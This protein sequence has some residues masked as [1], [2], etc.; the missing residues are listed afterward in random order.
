MALSQSPELLVNG[1]LE[2][3]PLAQLLVRAL[4]QRLEGT[5]VLQTP[6]GVK[7][8][9]L[10]LRGAPA[11]A[12]LATNLVRLAEVVVDLEL[13]PRS[14]A[15]STQ[16]R[17]VSAGQSHEDVLIAEGHL[18]EAG[19]YLALREL[20]SRQVLKLCDLPGETMFGVYRA[21]YLANEGPLTEWRVKPLPLVWRALVDHFPTDWRVQALGRLGEHV[22]KMR[23]EAPVSRYHLEKDE[24]AVIDMLKARPQSL[25]KLE[26]SGVAS[27][28]KVR[29]IAAALLLTRQLEGSAAHGAPVGTNEPPET[30]HSQPPPSK[31]AT[32][33]ATAARRPQVFSGPPAS[34]RQSLPS[35]TPGRQSPSPT[36]SSGGDVEVA[37]LR[38][39]IRDWEAHPRATFYEVLG[40][41]RDTDNAGI[42][43]AFF[44]L[45][46]TWHPDRLPKELHEQRA[47]VTKAFA[48]M[49]EAHQ[50]LSDKVRR[51]EYDEKIDGISPEEQEKVAEILGASSAF[52]R[53]EV[54]VKKKDYAAALIEAK[55]AFEGD[56]SQ[57]D[58]AGLFAWL[59]MREGGE[60]ERALSIISNALRR[61]PNNV[62]VLFFRAQILRK[63][64]KEAEAIRDFKKIIAI[65]PQH[66]EA[67][68]ELRVHEMRRR[69]APREEHS[70][71]LGRFRRKS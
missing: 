51:A 4:D 32:D 49:G 2:Q 63:A 12:K 42:R 62:R 30:P 1:R 15:V 35:A 18:D 39:L 57:A 43:A 29:K 37:A 8:A 54:L 27:A 22:L 53:A 61:E 52:Q 6:E 23:F 64:G 50:V 71:L 45:A 10:L 7:H 33:R 44:Q 16:K 69:G 59:L 41:T 19:L 13:I 25:A 26:E 68:R 48:R 24:T 20:L 67:A 66:V 46:R 56:A 40:V 58:Y 21:N 34:T 47:V 60:N 14:L 38:E 11:K 5:L 31:R 65:K 17:A 55:A 28:E 3:A 36:P 9:V 70:G